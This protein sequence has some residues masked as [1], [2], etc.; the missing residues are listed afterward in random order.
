V[1]RQQADQRAQRRALAATRLAD[2][3]EDLAALEIEADAVDRLDRS[4]VRREA[5]V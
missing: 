1:A 3:A 4:R 2:D 5:D